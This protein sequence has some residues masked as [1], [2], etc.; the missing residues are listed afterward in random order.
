MDWESRVRTT[1]VE[2]SGDTLEPREE[3]EARLVEV[4]V[5]EGSKL[6]RRRNEGGGSHTPWLYQT[7]FIGEGGMGMAGGE[8]EKGEKI[9]E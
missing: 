3:E 1:K 2:V 4:Q 9:M 7:C 5:E 8:G 6:G